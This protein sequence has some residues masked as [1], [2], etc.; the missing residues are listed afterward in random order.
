MQEHNPSYEDT[1]SNHTDDN[2]IQRNLIDGETEANG[3]HTFIDDEMSEPEL[4]FFCKEDPEASALLTK[5]IK[6]SKD[7]NWTLM[8]T[9][10]SSINS[11][12]DNNFIQ[13]SS[14]AMNEQL[15]IKYFYLG[16]SNFRVNDYQEALVNFIEAQK[17]HQYYQ[18]QYNIAL[19][20][21]KLGNLE[22]AVFYLEGAMKKN[23]H[24]FFAQYNLIKIYLRKNNTNDAFLIYRDFSEI[25]KKE[26][27]KEQFKTNTGIESG[28]RMSVV[29]FN[30]L[31][32]FYK[33]GA[34]CLFEKQLYQECVY[35]ILDAL[36]FNPEDAE[37]WYLY[38][39]VFVMKKTF[40]YAIPL[41]KKA[42]EIQ[43]DYIEAKK[44]LEFLEQKVK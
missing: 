27:D 37:I 31:K 24:F 3:I 12:N 5:C 9:Y 43:P 44:L 7:E 2:N 25:I 32:L 39:K 34:E 21:M 4:M 1:S 42:I 17:I 35:T 28:N 10:L 15:F 20:Y 22:N 11:D 29:S 6:W 14:N 13:Q 26:K 8:K 36:R 30:T 18:L 40:E 16:I 38:A 41:L 19:C 23:K 33:I